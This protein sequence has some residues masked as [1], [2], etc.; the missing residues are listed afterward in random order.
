MTT[1]YTYIAVFLGSKTSPRKKAWMAL[2]E[3]ERR[4]KGQEGMAAWKAW[5]E[6]D[7]AAV[8]A[9]RAA[10]LTPGRISDEQLSEWMKQVESEPPSQKSA[11]AVRPTAARP[12]LLQEKSTE[13][14]ERRVSAR[15]GR[16]YHRP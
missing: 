13:P 15:A 2:A 8:S 9:G 16:V 7:H 3:A 5:A 11:Q 14:F 1:N 10:Q 12:S 6:K 4:A